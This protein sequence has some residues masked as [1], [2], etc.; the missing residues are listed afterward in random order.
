MSPL[1]LDLG[2]FIK[3]FTTS[4]VK[5]CG[6]KYS[7]LI[8]RWHVWHIDIRLECRYWQR[9]ITTHWPR[10]Q[11]GNPICSI[12][13]N[14][15][16]QLVLWTLPVPLYSLVS[17]YRDFEVFYLF[18][19]TFHYVL[20]IHPIIKII[21]LVLRPHVAQDAPNKVIPS[22]GYIQ[23]QATPMR[24]LKTLKIR[25]R[26]RKRRDMHGLLKYSWYAALWYWKMSMQ[27]SSITRIWV[28]NIQFNN[29][30]VITS[31][32]FYS[33]VPEPA[34]RKLGNRQITGISVNGDMRWNYCGC[35]QCWKGTIP[36]YADMI[37]W[38][39]NRIKNLRWFVYVQVQ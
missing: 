38:C 17:C 37:V 12:H 27:R 31:T 24:I 5:I 9:V 32:D 7:I 3:N 36:Y 8:Q 25:G 21:C 39:R 29:P 2:E 22:S 28:R 20:I 18:I 26:I 15:H 30:S 1:F 34:F 23:L 19:N 13:W 14:H 35:S 33:K 10:G 4:F 16:N 11:I 6:C